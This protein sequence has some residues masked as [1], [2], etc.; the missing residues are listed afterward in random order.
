MRKW[1]LVAFAA[2]LAAS[3]GG[4]FGFDA[5]A[6]A[7]QDCEDWSNETNARVN[8]ARTLLYPIG[9]L[10]AFEGSADQAAAEMDAILQE[11]E[12]AQPPEGAG[13]IHDDLIEAMAAGVEGLIGGG[14]VD[15]TVQITF[16]KS[17]IYNA[18]ARLVTYVNTC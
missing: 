1:L 10:D 15:P 4:H 8:D 13:N 12:S 16:A 6:G 5:Q 9:R 11:Q 18:D 2:V 14:N 17:I 3:I 7:A